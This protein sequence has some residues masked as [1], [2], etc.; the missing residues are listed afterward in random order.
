MPQATRSKAMEFKL[1][2][3][4]RIL[5]AGSSKRFHYEGIMVWALLINLVSAYID[6]D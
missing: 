6:I 3:Y 5:R 1:T 2:W 4:G